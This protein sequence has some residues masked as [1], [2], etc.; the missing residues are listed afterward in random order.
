MFYSQFAD[1]IKNF[2]ESAFAARLK[3]A[4]EI[5]QEFAL[6]FMC[7]DTVITA[8]VDLF[9]RNDDGNSHLLDFKTDNKIPTDRSHELQMNIYGL[10]VRDILGYTVEDIILYYLRQNKAKVV[11]DKYPAVDN[12]KNTLT[13]IV[14][15]IQS[16][17]FDPCVGENCV[18]CGFFQSICSAKQVQPTK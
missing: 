13:Q 15:D 7:N 6:E 17:K 10:M 14:V 2:R 4:E 3:S 9:W 11:I 1:L 18:Y 5:K 12:T 8:T 16:N